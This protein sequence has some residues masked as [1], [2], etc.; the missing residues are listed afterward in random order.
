MTT[1]ALC[2]A[3]ILRAKGIEHHA[4]CLCNALCAGSLAN[5]ERHRDALMALMRREPILSDL[6]QALTQETDE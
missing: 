5:A 1:D 4:D 6:I 3:L 2:A